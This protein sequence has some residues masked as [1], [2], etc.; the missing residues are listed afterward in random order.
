MSAD[1]PLWLWLSRAGLCL[2]FLY[3]GFA[4]LLDFAGAIEEQTHFGLRPPALF[5][6]AT[7]VVQLMVAVL[8][9]RERVV[10]AKQT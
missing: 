2:V 1:N 7:I 9:L 3:S 10:A 4:K 8:A 5:P 6:A